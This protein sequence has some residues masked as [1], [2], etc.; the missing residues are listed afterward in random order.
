MTAILEMHLQVQLRTAGGLD[1]P[2]IPS[3]TPK[4][5]LTH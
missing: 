3:V 5:D 2:E 1:F 4:P